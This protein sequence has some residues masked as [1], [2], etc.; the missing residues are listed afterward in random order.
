MHARALEQ[1]AAELHDLHR[2]EWQ[3]LSVAALFLAAAV[4]ASVLLPSVALPLLVGGLLA[5][6]RA[7]VAIWRHWNLLDRLVGERDAQMIPEVR[8]R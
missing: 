5:T 7:V 3:D 1:S 6:A 4:A 8:R 2:A